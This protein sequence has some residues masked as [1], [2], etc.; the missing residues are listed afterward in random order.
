MAYANCQNDLRSH[1]LLH[2]GEKVVGLVCVKGGQTFGSSQSD[3]AD[4]G[5]V[6]MDEI[7]PL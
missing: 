2:R 7:N 3:V 4:D 6:M 5:G 1:Y